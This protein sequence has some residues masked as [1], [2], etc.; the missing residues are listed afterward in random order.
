MIWNPIAI[1][2][3][4]GIVIYDPVTMI[5][6]TEEQAKTQSD[7]IKRRLCLRGKVIGCWVYSLDEIKMM[8][9]ETSPK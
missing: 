9:N 2:Y 8:E 3:S 7:I 1:D 6:Y 4:K 5:E